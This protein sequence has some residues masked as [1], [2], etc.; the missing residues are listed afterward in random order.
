MPA[1]I[2]ETA[3]LMA[4][5]FK[6]CMYS[7]LKWRI[8][9]LA[10]YL[11]HQVGSRTFQIYNKLTGVPITLMPKTVDVLGNLVTASIPLG[12]YYSVRELKLGDKIYISSTGSGISLSQAGLVWD[13]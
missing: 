12:L 1:I 11:I 8:E 2:E 9:E 3:N 5:M 4:Q 7:R 6:E 13:T 10:K